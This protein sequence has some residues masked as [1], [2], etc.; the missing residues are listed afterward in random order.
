MLGIDG[1]PGWNDQLTA[2]CPFHDERHPSFSINVATGQWICFKG[3]GAGNHLAGLVA[4]YFDV[5][6][7]AAAHWVRDVAYVTGLGPGETV[8]TEDEWWDEGWYAEHFTAPPQRKLD[9]RGITSE[10]AASL[11]I[12]WSAG[13]RAW[14]LPARDPDT[15]VIRGWQYKSADGTWMETGTPASKTLFGIDQFETGA[16]AILVES[17]LDVAVL[18]TA[19]LTGD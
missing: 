19:E 1:T 8:D 3:C 6:Y 9:E 13:E 2:C 7:A 17:P 11:S 14:I 18:A 16:T 4:R 10:A 15:G 12:R 5:P